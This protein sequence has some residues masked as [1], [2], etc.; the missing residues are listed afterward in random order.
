MGVVKSNNKD[1]KGNEYHDSENGQFTSKDG[2]SGSSQQAENDDVGVFQL[3]KEKPK[4][5]I[6]IQSIQTF[7]QEKYTAKD[8]IAQ[9]FIDQNIQYLD[10]EKQK[11]Y[12]G[13]AREEKL[14]LLKNSANGYSELFLKFASDK[15]LDAILYAEAIT[16]RRKQLEQSVLSLEKNKSEIAKTI[17]LEIEK[18]LHEKYGFVTPTI[19]GVWFSEVSLNKYEEKAQVDESG[20]SAIDRKKEYYNDIINN[21]NSSL[22]QKADAFA[23][24]KDLDDFI[25][26]GEEL[27]AFK[28]ETKLKYLDQ[29]EQIENQ[30]SE[31][32]KQQDLFGVDSPIVLQANSF[33]EKFQDINSAYSK[34]RKD[35]ATWLKT[36]ESAYKHFGPRSDEIW[37]NHS[38]SDER[39]ILYTYTGSGYSKFNKPLRGKNQD[40]TGYSFN[41]ETGTFSQA[42]TNMTNAIDKSTWDEDIWLNRYIQTDT[43]MFILPGMK[44]ALSLPEMTELQMQQLVGT[45]FEDG[46]FVSCGAAKG[47]G[48]H[49]GNVVFNIYCPKG[50][51]MIYMANHTAAGKSENEMIIQRGY[52]YRIKKVEKSNGR[53]YV[54][55]EVVLGSD[56]NKPI[57]NKLKEIGNKHYYGPRGEAGEQYD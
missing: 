44:K 9:E 23:H 48:Y 53:Y 26:K 45:S 14:E 17:D 13:L 18:F 46:G 51:K 55:M 11:F 41:Y 38:T 29:L 31:N 4:L 42:I 37:D 10:E 52:S 35:K 43:K 22:S 19:K 1:G 3:H 50:T 27:L 21:P 7:L 36:L 30:F 24:L 6:N 49:T 57:G 32:K 16:F 40:P 25:Q 54:D 15:E 28:N 8:K 33:L 5:N 34:A 47:T 12:Q 56:K 20:T 2:G 39:D